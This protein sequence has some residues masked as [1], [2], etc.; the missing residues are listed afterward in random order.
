M[1]LLELQ[2]RNENIP[3][4]GDSSGMAII[5]K[6]NV[7]NSANGKQTE[8]F[9]KLLIAADKRI[10]AYILSLVYNHTDADDIFQETV[11]VMWRKFEEFQPDRDFVAW[12]VGIAHN[13]I[14]GFRRKKARSPKQFSDDVVTLLCKDSGKY[15]KELDERVELL[16]EC[17]WKLSD[18]D[19]HIM[20]LRYEMEL[21]PSD[22]SKRVGKSIHSVYRSI[23]RI[24]NILVRCVRRKL[25]GENIT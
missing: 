4:L 5:N 16:Q 17:V 24:H 18:N 2:I 25:A 1:Q 13:K 8:R 11:T 19:R 20:K 14:L 3:N 7:D 15:I 23:V 9:L 10:Y 6:S 22:I 12:G 21:T